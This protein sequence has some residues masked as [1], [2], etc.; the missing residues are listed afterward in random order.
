[1]SDESIRFMSALIQHAINKYGWGD[2]SNVE[3]ISNIRIG[4]PLF[5]GEI[6]FEFMDSF[7][8]ELEAQ[9]V[10][11]LEAYLSATGLKDYVLTEKEKNAIGQ[12]NELNW[13][14]FKL[15]DLFDHIKQGKRLKKD[16]QLPGNIPFIMSGT[17]NTGIANYISNPVNEFPRNSLTIDIFGNTFYRNFKFSASDDTGV[18]W[19][20]SV[21][22]SAKTMLCIATS[23]QRALQGKFSY[24]NKLRS[25]N[26]LDLVLELPVD[27]SENIDI[28]WM[29]TFITAIQKLVIKDVVDWADKNI[30]ATR[31]VINQ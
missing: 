2:G 8:A 14:K 10:A 20:E 21:E 27:R 16:D 25:S 15:R 28:Q 24:G 23:S 5:N 26:S 22:Y 30:A 1:M 12:F 17:T 4:L 18:Y 19:N 31:E 13:Q 3:S 9:R 11:E 7:I 6:D 29:D